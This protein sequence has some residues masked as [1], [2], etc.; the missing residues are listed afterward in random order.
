VQPSSFAFSSINT[1]HS[2]LYNICSWGSI[3]K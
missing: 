1:S 3:V 2:T